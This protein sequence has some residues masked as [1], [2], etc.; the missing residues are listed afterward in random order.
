MDRV[1]AFEESERDGSCSGCEGG[2]WRDSA[3]VGCAVGPVKRF[4]DFFDVL[5]LLFAGGE[6]IDMDTHRWQE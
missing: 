4:D 2:G 6:S 3:S 1:W 5:K